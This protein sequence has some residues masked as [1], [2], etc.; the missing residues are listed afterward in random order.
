MNCLSVFKSFVESI[1]EVI[2][3]TSN[4]HSEALHSQIFVMRNGVDTEKK[5][6]L[7]AN[8]EVTALR[9]QVTYQNGDLQFVILSMEETME[10]EQNVLPAF[11]YVCDLYLMQL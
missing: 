1:T 8:D 10:Q 4:N 6:C 3:K 5:L 7:K 11:Y 2:T 9:E